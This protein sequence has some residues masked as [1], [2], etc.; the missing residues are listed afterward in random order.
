MLSFDQLTFYQGDRCLIPSTQYQVGSGVI[1][2][3]L[4]ESGVGKSTFLHLIAG[5]VNPTSGSLSWNGEKVK[6]PKD[7]LVPGHPDIHLVRQ[8][9]GLFPNISLRENIRYA[10]RFYEALYREERMNYLIE[11]G[12]LTSIQYQLPREVSGGEQQ[13]AAILMAMA[14]PPG[15]LLL[16]EPFSHLDARNKHILRRLVLDLVKEEDTLV[17]F[18]THDAMDALS[19]ADQISVLGKGEWIQTADPKTLYSAPA[20]SY[21]AGLTGRYYS[22][23]NQ[24]VRPEQVR[25]SE[26]GNEVIVRESIYLG[27][28]YLLEGTLPNGEM[29]G[30][31]ANQPI[32]PSTLVGLVWD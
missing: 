2:A 28:H 24:I 12:G 19:T 22:I 13:R 30:W 31:Y 32:A 17:I 20:N 7:K 23:Q 27:P 16:D 21:V 26:T 9:A 5:L 14:E 8:N 11:K 1:W 3:I 10:L 18:V 15:V 25:M 4:G 6:P 29:M